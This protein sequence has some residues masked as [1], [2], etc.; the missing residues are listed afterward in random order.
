MT[1]LK[2]IAFLFLCTLSLSNLGIWSS[3][4]LSAS[5]VN[6]VSEEQELAYILEEE[7]GMTPEEVKAI[8]E[9]EDEFLQSSNARFSG[10]GLAAAIVYAITIVGKKLVKK[11]LTAIALYGYRK[12]CKSYSGSNR[13]LKLICAKA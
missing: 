3:P 13:A 1:K 11:A 6:N 9:M 12:A 7:L 8:E 2:K 5:D 10:I 4:I